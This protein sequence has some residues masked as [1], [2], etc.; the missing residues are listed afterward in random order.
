MKGQ[1]IKIISNDYFIEVNNKE[2]I[3]KA[4]GKLKNDNTSLKVGDY[5][6]FDEDKKIIE[7]VILR[8]NTLDRPFV[9]NIDIAFIVT[10]L[11]SPDFS[12]NLLDKFLVICKLNKI[13]P[14]IVITKKDL[15][16]KKEYNKI[17]YVLKYY[18]KIGYKIVYNTSISKIKRLINNNTV[19]FTG[20]TGS[21]KSTLINKLDK[22]LNF[23]TGE[24]SKALGRGKHTTRHVSLVKI[25]KGKVLDTPGFSSLSLESYSNEEIKNSF[26]EFNNYK[27]KYKDC[28]HTKEEGCSIKNNK[29][30]LKSRYNNYLK[31]IDKR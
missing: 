30:I 20:Q 29:N 27:C 2:Y 14:I 12:T 24:V 10:S 6:I 23:E 9:S 18:K 28:S 8:K 22:N 17:K 26:I 15:V 21:G 5:V 3:C 7:K 11:K 31:F 25:S 1:I 13:K 16:N 19:V 4:R